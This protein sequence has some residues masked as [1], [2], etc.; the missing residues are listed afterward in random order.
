MR[1]GK[2]SVLVIG[3]AIF[4][5]LLVSLALAAEYSAVVVTKSQGHQMQGKIYVKGANIRRDFSTPQG[6]SISIVRGDKKV[7]WML[8]PGQKMYMEMPFSRETLSKALNLP[9][10][11][12]SMKLLGTEKI[13]GY[14]TDK[15]E[16]SVNT[17]KGPAKV[18]L[19]MAKKLGAPVRMENADKSFTQE[20]RDIKEGEVSDQLFDIPA[21]YKKM[22]MPAGMPMMK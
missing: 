12:A 15:Y 4:S 18:T 14:E 8:M 11:K 21:G 19:W 17:G 13:A 3:L 20:Y 2:I 7:M 1:N 6:D 22:S 9:E 16:S 5:F 10:N